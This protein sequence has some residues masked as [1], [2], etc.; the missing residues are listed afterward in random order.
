MPGSTSDGGNSPD[1]TGAGSSPCVMKEL[2]SNSCMILSGV[3]SG[4]VVLLGVSILTATDR[5]SSLGSV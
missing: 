2:M 4:G 3:A 5:V 1:K